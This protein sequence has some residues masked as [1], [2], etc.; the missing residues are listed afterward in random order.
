MNKPADTV[1]SICP[2][3]ALLLAKVFLHGEMH[4][5]V[6]RRWLVTRNKLFFCLYFLTF[7]CLDFLLVLFPLFFN[8][9]FFF[10]FRILVT[11]P[12][13]SRVH[14][15]HGKP[16]QSHLNIHIM[17]EFDVLNFPNT[18][19]VTHKTPWRPFASV[20]VPGKLNMLW[21]QKGV[22]S[23][24]DRENANLDPLIP[25]PYLRVEL[26]SSPKVF[27]LTSLRTLFSFPSWFHLVLAPLGPN[28]TKALRCSISTLLYFDSS[29]VPV[30]YLI[31]SIKKYKFKQNM[32]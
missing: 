18:F 21:H 10:L 19:S 24:F 14:L 26:Q 25:T 16:I 13:Q 9:F 4:S 15:D 27:G 12:L 30:S 1:T 31:L 29:D 17:L 7:T 23:K 8:F 32:I 22:F 3:S 11:F 2:L 5:I 6:Q 28:T 20:L